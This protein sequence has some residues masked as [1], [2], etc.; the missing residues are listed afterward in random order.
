MGLKSTRGSSHPNAGNKEKGEE[1]NE[2]L[3]QKTRQRDSSYLRR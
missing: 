2:H 1:L 3:A